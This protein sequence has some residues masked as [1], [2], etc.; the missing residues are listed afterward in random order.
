MTP[1]GVRIPVRQL[2]VCAVFSPAAGEG[3]PQTTPLGAWLRDIVMENNGRQ[4]TIRHSSGSHDAIVEL[5]FREL[6]RLGWRE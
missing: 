2:Y 4:S 3:V 1:S 6:R 5:P